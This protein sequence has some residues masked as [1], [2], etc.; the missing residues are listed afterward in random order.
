MSKT[1]FLLAVVSSF[2][3]QFSGFSSETQ[4][5][6]EPGL[7][8]WKDP[9]LPIQ[10]RVEYLLQHMTL[11]EKVSELWHDAPA[12]PRLHLPAYNYSSECLHGIARDG[13]ATVFPQA[14]GMAAAW[15]VSLMHA[16]AD[17]IGTE[18]RAKYND[19]SS[20]HNGD[21]IRYYGLTYWTPNINIFRDPRWGRG[22][23]TYGEDPFLA[24]RLAVA[25]I[26]GL[27]G[28]DPKYVKAMACA[29]HFAVHSGPEP[30]RHV[31]DARP[32][33]RDFYETYLPQFE[34]AV[35]EGHVGGV[36]GAYTSLYGKPC[37]M[38]SMLLTDILRR[39]WGFDGYVVS[40]CG[41]I[42]D[43]WLGHKAAGTPQQAAALAVKAGCDISCYND[44]LA[45]AGAV[46][47][48]LISEDE[49]DVALGHVLTTRFRLGL[50]DPPALV[51]YSK[52][53][54]AQNDT[55]ANRALA[56]KVAEESI[57]LLKNDGLL[58]LDR[59]KI[60]SIAVIG[61]N[62]NAVPMLLSSYAGTPSKTVAILE[63]I[64]ALAGPNVRVD[65][66]QGCPL[67]LR[68]DGT[69]A[70]TPE[71]LARA[72]AMAGQ[73]DVIIYV[74]GINSGLE[75]EEM[76]H[77]NYI[78]FAG[79]DRTQIE[80][81]K[82]QTELLK[83]LHATG[84]PVVF[85]NCSGSAVAMP[86]EAAHLP[87]IVQAWYPGE[88]GGSAVAKVLFGESN[89]AGRL[90]ITFYRST[91]D[92]PPFEDYAMSNRT[93]RYFSGKPLFAFGHGL[94]YTRF[95]YKDVTINERQAEPD[96]IIHVR[97]NVANVG[98]RDGDEVVQVYFR[99]IN[100]SVPQPHEALCGFHRLTVPR[101]E[102]VPV[103]ITIPV[104]TFRYWDTASR[105]YAVEAGRY[106]L[107]VGAA[108]DDIRAT[109]PLRV[110]S[111]ASSNR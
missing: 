111:S 104:K 61:A 4:S 80:L 76:L 67:A 75:G 64:K 53:T 71:A 55:P 24:G 23:E 19:Y 33:E 51:P 38:S 45:L 22:Q 83:A 109:I 74:G 36:M 41:A 10:A 96:D 9:S 85:V 18:A 59:A 47:N 44:Y 97:L 16:E 56:R 73:A 69:N 2:L 82:V 13:N 31:F 81:P 72:V 52:I 93:Y 6:V 11:E 1:V 78:G 43:I 50:F 27:Q 103:E 37:C 79:G 60:K 68:I 54:L 5:H 12:I 105:Q 84:K 46:T 39:Q 88:E 8:A 17:V 58:P 99:H 91:A 89:P 25:F 35:R 77:T 14:I 42:K 28:D 70:P 101:G 102:T 92:L 87:A 49:I 100:S 15:D 107:L 95:K 108:S 90:P 65:Y 48:G 7:D 40:D 62:A 94:S 20:K 57:V 26:R 86:W 21:S 63:G 30:L 29:K 34:A 106:E 98:R 66:A 32:P 3:F 110:V